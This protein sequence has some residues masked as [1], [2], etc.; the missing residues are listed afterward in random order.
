MSLWVQVLSL[1]IVLLTIDCLNPLDSSILNSYLM[2]ITRCVLIYISGAWASQML[3]Q[4]SVAS[5]VQSSNLNQYLPGVHSRHILCPFPHVMLCFVSS[6]RNTPRRSEEEFPVR[7]I[8][9]QLR[10]PQASGQ[11]RSAHNPGNIYWLSGAVENIGADQLVA[12]V[13]GRV[14]ATN[15]AFP[16]K[17]HK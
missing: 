14:I 3:R 11:H 8:A 7:Y 9:R 12:I 13:G 4:Q 2:T 15:K 10:H 6:G 17:L 16:S 1:A 5:R